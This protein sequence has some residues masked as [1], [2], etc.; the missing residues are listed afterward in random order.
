MN[1]CYN[2]QFLS[3]KS[4]CYNECG[5]I[6]SANITRAC[7]RRVRPS[8]FLLEHQS[9]PVLSF[10]RFSYQFSLTVHAYAHNIELSISESDNH[11]NVLGRHISL[12]DGLYGV[13]ANFKCATGYKHSK[14]IPHSFCIYIYISLCYKSE[15]RG[16]DT[17]WWH[18]NFS[19]K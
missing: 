1:E 14:M 11:R 5:G 9:S 18:W 16:F 15:G 6:L 17:L 10:V 4:G 19:L 7:V 12:T 13:E 8:R 3:I 2:E